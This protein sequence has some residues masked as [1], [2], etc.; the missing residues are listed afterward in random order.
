MGNQCGLQK[1]GARD[2]PFRAL[3]FLR[4]LAALPA[5]LLPGCMSGESE[6]ASRAADTANHSPFIKAAS[7]LPSPLVLAGPISVRVEAQDLAQQT[8]VFRYRWLV[9]GH[10]V[11]GQTQRTLPSQLLKRGDQV[12][13]EVI[14][15]NGAV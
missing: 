7:I 3:S 8:M 11:H 5:L 1:K 13:V 12:A 4:I 10:I 2:R 15:F 14:P 6:T 9:N